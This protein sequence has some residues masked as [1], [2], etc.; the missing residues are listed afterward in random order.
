[1]NIT[2]LSEYAFTFTQDTVMCVLRHCLHHTLLR[3]RQVFWNEIKRELFLISSL[4][5]QS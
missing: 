3:S 1:M 5:A 2:H 4:R